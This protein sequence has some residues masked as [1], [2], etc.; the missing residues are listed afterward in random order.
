MN[1][2]F[3]IGF[4][5]SCSTSS[6]I[7]IGGRVSR[8]AEYT[9]AVVWDFRV[10]DAMLSKHPG[11]T[12]PSRVLD[13]LFNDTLIETQSP[14]ELAKEAMRRE[15]TA[16]A[17][18]KAREICK[19]EDGMEYPDVARLCRVID[20]D[21]RLVVIDPDLIEALRRREPVGY[22]QLLLHSVQMWTSKIVNLPIVPVFNSR[23]RGSKAD[24]LYAWT[25]AYDP[26]FLGYMAGV[27]PLLEG[28][29][30]GCFIA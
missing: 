28:L 11:F 9:E 19:N 16:G 14:S 24:T 26:D 7:Q 18:N 21:T 30:D 29:K 4:R 23:A 13:K 8:N 20:S 17:E 15:V 6:L 5:E 3:R 27:I 10:L 22:R 1:F 12:V 2:S 25:A